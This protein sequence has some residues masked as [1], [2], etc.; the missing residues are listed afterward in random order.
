MLPILHKREAE[1]MNWDA[2]GAVG[3]FVGAAA[4][5]ISLVYL[6][7]Q[8]RAQNREARLA[9]MHEITVGFRDS[10]ATI[11]ADAELAKL[12]AT[13]NDKFDALSDTEILRLLAGIQ[14]MLRVWEEAFIQHQEARLDARI[15]KTMV[16]QYASFL[17]LPTISHI[18]DLRREFYDDEFRAFVDELQRTEYKF[19]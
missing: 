7:V 15:W 14:R 13:A 3:E 5:V 2:V 12:M 19:R 1:S 18:W 11:A 17:S 16:R 4:V 6:A 10:I 8:I 9:A